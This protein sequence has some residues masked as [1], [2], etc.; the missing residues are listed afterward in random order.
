MADPRVDAA[1]IDAVEQLSRF[2]GVQH[3]RLTLAGGVT[4]PAYRRGRIVRHHL[5]DDEPVEQMADGR[6]A[7]LDGRCR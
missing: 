2:Y 4:G 5:P 3:R 6:Q 1:A 7:L